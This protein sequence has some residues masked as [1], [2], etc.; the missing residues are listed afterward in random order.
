MKRISVTVL[1]CTRMLF[2]FGQNDSA[3]VKANPTKSYGKLSINYLNNSVYNGRQ[4]SILTPYI[5]PSLG[6]YDKSGF[7]IDGS[8]SYLARSGSSRIDLFNIEAG[9]DF[10]AGDF[11]G[12]ISAG[13]SF[14]NTNSTN[15]KAEVTGSVLSNVAYDFGF[16]RPHLEGGINFGKKPDYLLTLGLEHSFHTVS[17]R[18]L[19]TPSFLANASTRNYYG[20]YYNKR[21]IGGRRKISNGIT[22]TATADV[23][24]A[25]RFKFLDYEFSLPVEYTVHQFIFSITPTYAVPTNPAV[26]TVQLIP[27]TGQVPAP[28]TITENIANRFY[29]SFEIGIKF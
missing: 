7:Y 6:Y 17:E 16:I 13:K 29:C 2:G 14:Y 24:D 27:S 11:D 8:L 5:T 12:G 28:K 18:L 25:S 22:Y 21:K 1:L 23:R 15:V 4:D 3:V 19:V 9:Y 20:S 26:V 10:S